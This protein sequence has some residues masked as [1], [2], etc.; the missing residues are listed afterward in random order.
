VAKQI[1]GQLSLLELL[2][3]SRFIADLPQFRECGSCWCYDCRYNINN[4]AIPRD[5]V[6]E[7]KPCPSCN[8]CLQAGSADVCE[9]GSY[10]NGCKVRAADEGIIV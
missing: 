9:I 5:L 4:E 7:I 2:E 8:F 6:G 1:E 3:E 10:Q